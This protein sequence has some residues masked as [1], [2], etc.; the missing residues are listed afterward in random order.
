ME[1]ERGQF[2]PTVKLSFCINYLIQTS[3]KLLPL[4]LLNMTAFSVL[5][6]LSHKVCA[7]VNSSLFKMIHGIS[8]TNTPII[9]LTQIVLM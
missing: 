2:L 4:I 3:C 8:C 1:L 7:C 6:F 9:R 5:S